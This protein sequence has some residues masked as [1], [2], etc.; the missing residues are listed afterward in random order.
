MFNHQKTNTFY[1]DTTF[2]KIMFDIVQS[3]KKIQY[4]SLNLQYIF[5]FSILIN[6]LIEK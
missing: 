5:N 3:D 2:E 4:L 6:S 1:D